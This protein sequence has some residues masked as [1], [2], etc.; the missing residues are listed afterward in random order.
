MYA[1]M[2]SI[3]NKKIKV[4]SLRT[5]KIGG[6]GDVSTVGGVQIPPAASTTKIG[7]ARFAILP[8]L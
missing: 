3:N 6:L 4:A 8:L 1:W 7:N 2:T 5:E